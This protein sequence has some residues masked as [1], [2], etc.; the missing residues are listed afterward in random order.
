MEK[1][2]KN[3]KQIKKNILESE[4]SLR[5]I[6]KKFLRYVRNILGWYEERLKGKFEI[7]FDKNLKDI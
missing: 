6:W 5:K 4:K 7:K 1:Y 2:K 3:L